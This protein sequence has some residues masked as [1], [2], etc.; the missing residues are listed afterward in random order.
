MRLQ[1]ENSCKVLN[2]TVPMQI[3]T[4]KLQLLLVLVCIYCNVCPH[5][6][7]LLSQFP[8]FE[9][10]LSFFSTSIIQSYGNCFLLTIS[11]FTCHTLSPGIEMS[12][13]LSQ[14]S[15]SIIVVTFFGPVIDN[16]CIQDL[17]TLVI[18]GS[19]RKSAWGMQLTHKEKQR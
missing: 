9:E 4:R 13:R 19:W 12:T 5:P 10:L 3:S 8:Y 17:Q 14:A 11:K 7:L 18:L 16:M 2:S 1:W 15:C 6:S